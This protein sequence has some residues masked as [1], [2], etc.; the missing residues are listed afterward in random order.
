MKLEQSNN[1]KHLV[2][3]DVLLCIYLNHCF[4]ILRMQL[5]VTT[6]KRVTKN[7]IEIIYINNP[8]KIVNYIHDLNG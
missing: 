4:C 8:Y 5:Q 7:I 3:K 6:R 2:Y 1:Q